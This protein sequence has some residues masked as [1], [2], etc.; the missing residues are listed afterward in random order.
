MLMKIFLRSGTGSH[1]VI[2]KQLK[3]K[4]N[5][6]RYMEPKCNKA[7]LIK[8]FVSHRPPLERLA[9]SVG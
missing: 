9:R 1:S 3:K 2:F 5:E 7:I 6:I 4:M 8:C